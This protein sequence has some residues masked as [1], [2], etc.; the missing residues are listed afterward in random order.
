[1]LDIKVLFAATEVVRI[2]LIILGTTLAAVAALVLIGATCLTRACNI[3][4]ITKNEKGPGGH[5][6]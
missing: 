2:T 4:G 3:G 1:M 6:E 5:S